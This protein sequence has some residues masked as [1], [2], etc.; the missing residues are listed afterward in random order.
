MNLLFRFIKRILE[1][2]QNG[3]NM[4]DG[5]AIMNLLVCLVE[6]NLG[7]IDA[8]LPT[9]LDFVIQELSFCEIHK[10]TINH[11]KYKAMILQAL[12]MI[13]NYNAAMTF[14]L[15]EAKGSTL[16]I[17]Q[18]WFVF[19]NEFKKDFEV[20]RIL[21]GLTAIVTAPNLPQVVSEK[22]PDIMNQ[23][24]LLTY[25]M[26]SERQKSLKENK[27]HVARDG[28][29]SSDDEEDDEDIG[30]NEEV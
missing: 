30:D 17:F 21:L 20:R 12:S 3:K 27:E 18:T 11:K 14:Q 26:S 28:K 5:L 8:E 6:N 24:S 19:M 25:K 13:F 23:I 10:D 2:N 4:V 15:I 16:Q 7:Q 1:V 22:L 9:I 29:D